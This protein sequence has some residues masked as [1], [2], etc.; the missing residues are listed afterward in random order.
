MTLD[1][2]THQLPVAAGEVLLT[3]M[4]RH[5]LRPP[6][7]CRSGACAACKCRVT[8]GE[9]HLR[10]NG[11]LTNAEL[12]EGWTLACQAEAASPRVTLQY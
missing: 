6:S 7:A 2:H 5:G 9:V 11:A 12:A 3:A 4:E 1:G 10:E 8:S